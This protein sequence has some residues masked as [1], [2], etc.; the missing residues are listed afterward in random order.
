MLDFVFFM[1]DDMQS[2]KQGLSSFGAE[3]VLI[4]EL[5]ELMNK[6]QGFVAIDEF[7]KGT[8]PYEGKV[9]VKAF[10][11]YLMK[12]NT[13]SLLTTHYDG[14]LN[15]DMIHYQ[16]TGLKDANFEN[17]LNKLNSTSLKTFDVIQEFMDYRLEKVNWDSKVPKEAMKVA[18]I[19]GFEGEILDRASNLLNMEEENAK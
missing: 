1:S 8:N 16:V 18:S 11:E 13:I 10:F 19:L 7:A 3:I 6:K 15:K 14:V 9:I 17:I 5:L 12:F 2:V 4:K